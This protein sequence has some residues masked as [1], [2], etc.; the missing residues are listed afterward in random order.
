MSLP[1]TLRCRPRSP[2]PALMGL[3][4]EAGTSGAP[5]V[6]LFDKFLLCFLLISSGPLHAQRVQAGKSQDSCQLR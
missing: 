5:A 2:S 1:L 6:L 3:Q 4:Q